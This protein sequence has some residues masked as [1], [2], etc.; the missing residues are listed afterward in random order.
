MAEDVRALIAEA[1]ALNLFTPQGAF[2][3]HC[4]YCHARLDARGDCATC[5]LIGRP[6]SELERRAQ[7]DADGTAKLLRTAI[8]KR[9]SFKPV[10]AR[11]EKA[12][13]R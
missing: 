4:S 9:K 6:A 7:T 8:D 5:G 1:A 11:G 12:Q 3:V 10:G 13:E 2:E